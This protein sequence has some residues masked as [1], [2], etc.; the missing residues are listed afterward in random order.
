[1]TPSELNY[2]GNRLWFTRSL[3]DKVNSW[4]AHILYCI[5]IICYYVLYS[6]NKVSLRKNVIR[7]SSGRE[8]TFTVFFLIL[9][10]HFLFSKWIICQ[11]LHQYCLIWSKTLELVYILLAL[12]IRNEKIMRKEIYV[13]LPVKW[14]VRW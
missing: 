10:L 3:T 6:Y 1:M 9:C 4:L 8:N 2:T 13:Y 11:Y 5:C 14:S 7:K 12:D